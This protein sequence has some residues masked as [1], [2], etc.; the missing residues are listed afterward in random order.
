MKPFF[1]S[2]QIFENALSSVIYVTALH[3]DS[4]RN[5]LCKLY[6]FIITT[7]KETDNANGALFDSQI[8][9]ERWPKTTNSEV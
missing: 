4:L 2:I 5:L 7:N 6:F 1:Q 8:K 3:E 9:G